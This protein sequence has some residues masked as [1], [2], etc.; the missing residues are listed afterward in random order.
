MTSAV[1]RARG[2]LI[3]RA[4]LVGLVTVLSPA[5]AR[6]DATPQ[7]DLALLNQER[8]AWGLPAGIIENPTWSADCAAHDSYERENGG[9][10]THPEQ[11]GNPGYST[12][13]A[14]AGA[15]SILGEGATWSALDNPFENA[16]IHL[17]GTRYRSLL[18]ANSSISITLPRVR[19][20]NRLV[21]TASLSTFTTG[22][23]R[24]EFT[25]ATIKG[26]L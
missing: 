21:V 18:A 13:G 9:A 16:P 6:A 17:V 25:P 23:S 24:F 5:L 2:R 12:G 14:F 11:S 20:A 1:R 26:F 8:A 19:R 3:A 7:A 15:N 4:G 22:T 10:L